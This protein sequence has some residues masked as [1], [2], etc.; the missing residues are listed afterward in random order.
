[1][2]LEDW[3]VIEEICNF[4]VG[5][6]ISKEDKEAF[7]LTSV[8]PV[9]VRDLNFANYACKVLAGVSDKLE[10]GTILHSGSRERAEQIRGAR[11]Y[12]VE[13]GQT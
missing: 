7:V 10:K 12:R 8:S 13:Q 1:M 4:Q 9:E 6:A 5:C 2:R 11:A 3:K